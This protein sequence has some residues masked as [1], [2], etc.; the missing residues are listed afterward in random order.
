MISVHLKSTGPQ[1]ALAPQPGSINTTMIT[2]IAIIETSLL[3]SLIRRQITAAMT[4]L[5]TPC[6][7]NVQIHQVILS[8]LGRLILSPKEEC[9]AE[10]VHTVLCE[11]QLV[12]DQALYLSNLKRHLQFAAADNF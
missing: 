7:T 3:S 1:G 9:Y 8:H 2:V 10:M 11:Q 5:K 12:I 4:H 6:S